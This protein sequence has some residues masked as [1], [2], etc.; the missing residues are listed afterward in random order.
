MAKPPQKRSP[1]FKHKVALE[2]L[3]G[4]QTIVQLGAQYGLHPKQIQRWRDQ[5]VIE[6]K[7]IFIHKTSRKARNP[8]PDK[9]ELLHIIEKLHLELEFLKKKLRNIP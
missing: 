2:A 4:D 1:D 9:T 7:D 6:S 3:K 8:D 5:L